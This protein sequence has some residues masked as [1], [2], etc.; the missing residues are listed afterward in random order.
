MI[1]AMQSS[2]VRAG[3]ALVLCAVLVVGCVGAV[4][5]ARGPAAG[6]AKV[7][8]GIYDSRAVALAFGRSAENLKEINDL[9]GEAQRAK[10]AGDQQRFDALDGKLKQ[11]QFM[12]HAQVFSNAPPVE[13]LAKLEKALPEIAKAEGVV[14]I[15]DRV[16]FRGEGVETVDLTQ[17]LVEEF[18]PTAETRRMAGEMKKAPMIDLY[19]ATHAEH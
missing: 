18:K 6:E 1:M 4:G 15:V 8:I 14:A 7:R 17:R 9:S 11:R 13:A 5:A 16:A 10:G 19:T 3:A 2:M 12:L